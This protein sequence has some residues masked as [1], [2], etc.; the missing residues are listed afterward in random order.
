MPLWLVAFGV[1]FSMGVG[2]LSG[3]M[4]ARKAVRIPALDAIRRE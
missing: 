4:P 2:L 1:L 3:Y